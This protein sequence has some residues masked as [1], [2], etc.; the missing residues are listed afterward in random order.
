MTRRSL[1]HRKSSFGPETT[2]RLMLLQPNIP[3]RI[4]QLVL[5]DVLNGGKQLL[6]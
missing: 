1:A 2:T 3:R 5:Y 4:V 6:L